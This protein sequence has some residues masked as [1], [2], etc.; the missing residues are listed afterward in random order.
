MTE[1]LPPAA[2][3]LAVCAHPDDESFGL[4]AVLAAFADAGSRLAVVCFTRGEAS[5][6]HGV[7]GDLRSVRATELAD[8]GD[9]L[10]IARAELLDYPDGRLTDTPLVELAEAVVHTGIATGADLLLV[11]DDGGIT[12][13]P[14]HQHATDS[15]RLAAA[16]LGVPVLAWAIPEVV[17]HRLNC[18]FGAAFVG[19]SSDQLDFQVAVTRRRQLEAIACHR[20]Q[21]ADNPVLWRR[22]ELLGGTEHLRYLI[23]TR[24]V[25]RLL[26]V[27]ELSPPL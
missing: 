24:P 23:R 21:S 25:R 10:G 20:S 14:D 8:A 3:V 1:T 15:A 5:T 7:A 6:L 13:H 11:F 9:M 16:T 2:N 27:E 26:P 12:G 4:G 19:R 18:E 17:A 22:L